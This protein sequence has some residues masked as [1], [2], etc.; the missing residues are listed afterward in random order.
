MCSSYLTF[1][2]H[3]LFESYV[4]SILHREIALRARPLLCMAFQGFPME[5]RASSQRDAITVQ[6]YLADENLWHYVQSYS[7]SQ[8]QGFEDDV[9]INSP[10]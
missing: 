4:W 1:H 10:G 9:L 6:I 5:G 2:I 7:S 8:S 3:I